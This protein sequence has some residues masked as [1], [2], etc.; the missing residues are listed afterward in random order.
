MDCPHCGQ[1]VSK[2]L[3]CDECKSQACQHCMTADGDG[4][5]FCSPSCGIAIYRD[6]ARY[7]AMSHAQLQK[8][9]AERIAA[10]E[11]EA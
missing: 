5:T 9:Y 4:N 3:K 2:L 8:C 6:L 11:A 10:L 7:E 1:E